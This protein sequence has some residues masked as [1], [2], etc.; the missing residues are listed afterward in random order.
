M[1]AKEGFVN[2]KKKG[3]NKGH[4]SKI[5]TNI[6]FNGKKNPQKN[7]IFFLYNLE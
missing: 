4:I 5:L 6:T 7:W 2:S 3:T 1:K